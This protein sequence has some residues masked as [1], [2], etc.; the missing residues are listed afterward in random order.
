MP[1]RAQRA[2]A[3]VKV[4]FETAAECWLE[5][6]QG[7][8]HNFDAIDILLPEI[9]KSQVLSCSEKATMR[10]ALEQFQAMSAPCDAPEL[11]TLYELFYQHEEFREKIRVVN[12]R[13]LAG[14]RLR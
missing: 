13:I 10:T 11:D 1:C 12:E 5:M 14:D 9:E 4:D 8:R 6:K 3:R 2:D 7:G